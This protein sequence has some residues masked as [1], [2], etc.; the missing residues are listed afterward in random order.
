MTSKVII[1]LKFFCE[2]NAKYKFSVT[3]H[4]LFIYFLKMSELVSIF[5]LCTLL[6]V[7]NGQNCSDKFREFKIIPDIID[8]FESDKM[9]NVTFLQPIECGVQLTPNEVRMTPDV[10][11]KAKID[12]FFTL[13]MTD[14]GAKDSEKIIEINHWLIMNIPGNKI[15]EGETAVEFVSAMPPKV[16]ILIKNN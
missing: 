11:W 8:D 9:L 6:A 10:E 7:T 5:L 4:F 13:L 1:G 12:E 3:K 14:C 2:K 16:K 15:S